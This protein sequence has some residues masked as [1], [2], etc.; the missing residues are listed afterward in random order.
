MKLRA[1]LREAWTTTWATKVSSILTIVV[2]LAMCMAAL[3]TVGRS[4]AAA[5]EV[6]QRMEQAGARRLSVTDTRDGGFVNSRT[7]SVV[8][9]VSSVEAANALGVPFDAV[10]GH[11]GAGGT[12]LPVWPILG[13]VTHVGDIVRGRIP[14][15]G[16]AAVSVSQMRAWGLTEPVGYLAATDQT[17]QYPIVGA[18]R[19]KPPFE[20][21]AAGGIV[22]ASPESAGRELR[23]VIDDVTSTRPTVKSI[24]AILSPPDIQG[25]QVESP[26]A[27]AG[28]ARDLNTQMSG[29]GRTL[30][31]LIL[32]AGGFFVAAVVLAD[33]LIRRHDLGRRRTLGITRADLIALVGVRTLITALIGATLGCM[34]GWFANQLTGH[35]TPVYF[36]VAIG[37]LAVLV[38]AAAAL[39]PAYYASRLDPVRVMRTP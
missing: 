23:V 25:V 28:T 35:P 34:A 13:E 26:A 22:A 2:A 9:H 10:N 37:V 1:L 30:L 12:R 31:L 16:E 32:A 6:A 7:L 4:A 17:G 19:A 14:Q 5:S 18:Y 15:P 20:D 24:L 21:L 11:I 38:A 27:L 39:P 29:F 8:Q 3:V 33:V 36:T